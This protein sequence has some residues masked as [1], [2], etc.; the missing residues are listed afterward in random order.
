VTNT[1]QGS[2]AERRAQPRFSVSVDVM[3]T[4]MLPEETF[5]PNQYRG[6]TSDISGG[7]CKL[8]TF[9]ITKGEYLN[10]LRG[11][12]FAKIEFHFDEKTVSL[13]RGAIVWLDFHDA[14]GP[15]DSSYCLLGVAFSHKD[16]T[17]DDN[18]EKL[19]RSFGGSSAA[20]PR[21]KP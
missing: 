5:T 21:L 9:Q 10:L 19:R 1:P 8:K 3:L 17:F 2:G 6:V 4:I 14:S 20:V 18:L 7:G 13:A 15:R 11:I 12:R 16:K